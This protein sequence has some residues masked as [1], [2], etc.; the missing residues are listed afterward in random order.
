MLNI[1]RI[2]FKVHE[3]HISL[4][5]IA[6]KYDNEFIT[7]DY[8]DKSLMKITRFVHNADVKIIINQIDDVD[9]QKH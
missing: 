7:I 2:I 6:I 9:L 1:R 4:L 5:V 8:L 3:C